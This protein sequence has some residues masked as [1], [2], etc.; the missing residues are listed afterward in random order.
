VKTIKTVSITFLLLVPLIFIL[1]GATG[2][3]ENGITGSWTFEVPDAPW[4]YNNGKLMFTKVDEELNGKIE[5]HTGRELTIRSVTIGEDRFTFVVYV[6]GY[7]IQ[8]HLS[9]D[10]NTLTGYAETPEGNMNIRAE[11][12][13][14]EG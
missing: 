5:F 12:E 8:T 11:L 6:D 2:I 4:E 9:R 10:G 14:A 3:D 13:A 1:S 7:R